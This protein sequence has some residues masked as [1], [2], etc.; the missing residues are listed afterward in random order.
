MNKPIAVMFAAALASAPFAAHAQ[1]SK[2]HEA[3]YITKEEV[4][5]VNKTPGIDRT[6]RVMDIG[7]EH[8]SVGVIH[9]GP[10][11]AAAPTAPATDT[12][13]CG[14]PEADPPKDL[15][16]GLTH[17]KQTEGY[18]VISGE[19][20]LVTGGHIVNGHMDPADSDVATI[21]NGP[22]CRGVIGGADMVKRFVK[23]GDIVIVPPGV[24]HG[25]ADVKD[26]VDYLSFRP[27]GDAL[28]AGY[29]NPAIK[30]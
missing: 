10:N 16:A 17:D 30:K 19:G 20:V 4:D 18:Y 14:T 5:T 22:T 11:T 12:P 3:Y 1:N 21:L 26:H 9:R 13:A 8:F 23:T 6:I 7:N 15:T 2:P 29:V 25:W 28:P 24:P 27:S